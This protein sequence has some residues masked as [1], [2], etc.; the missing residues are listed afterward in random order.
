VK[1]LAKKGVDDS[2]SKASEYILYSL[3]VIVINNTFG[4]SGI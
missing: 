1:G 3:Q 4:N 2:V